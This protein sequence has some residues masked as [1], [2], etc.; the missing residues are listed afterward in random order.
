MKTRWKSVSV[1]MEG[2]EWID[3]R[4]VKDG[5]CFIYSP[6]KETKTILG[7][8]WWCVCIRDTLASLSLSSYPP[9]SCEDFTLG[10]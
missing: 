9:I 8:V 3:L 4:G 2:R 10:S 1:E 5:E 7:T 6:T